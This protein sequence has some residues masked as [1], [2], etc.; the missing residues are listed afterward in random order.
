M[1]CLTTTLMRLFRQIYQFANFCGT[2]PC[3]I[4]LANYMQQHPEHIQELPE[5]LSG[6]T[7]PFNTQIE[8]SRLN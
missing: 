3:Q 8:N 1:R 7:G 4:A 5:L 6:E 2:T